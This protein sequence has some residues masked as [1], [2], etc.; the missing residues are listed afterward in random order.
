VNILS[1]WSRMISNN[2]RNG[3]GLIA[4]NGQDIKCFISTCVY[5]KKLL[6][7]QEIVLSLKIVV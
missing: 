6:A 3:Y 4:V 5:F 1:A 7:A 2:L